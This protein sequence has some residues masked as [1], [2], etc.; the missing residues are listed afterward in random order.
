MALL[1][2]AGEL[3]KRDQPAQAGGITVCLK[4]RLARRLLLHSSVSLLISFVVLAPRPTHSQ[5]GRQ[6][7]ANTNTTPQNSNSNT[8][9][10]QTSKS[11]PPTNSTRPNVN[12]E[13]ET[14]DVVRVNSTLVPVPATVVD[15]RGIAV[16]NLKLEDFELRIDGQLSVIS[17]LARAETPVRMAMLFDNSGSLSEFREFEKRAAIRFFH[18]V[19]RPVDQAAVFSVSTDVTLAEPLTNDARRLESTIASFG[20]PEGATSLFDAIIQAGAYLKPYAGRRIIVIVSDGEDTTSRADFDTTLQRALADDCQIYVV[21]TGLYENANVRALAAERRMEEFSSQ[22][23]G[24][25]YIPRTTQDLD[26]AFA[27]IAADLAQQYILSYYPAPDKRD[28]H[29]HLIALTVKSRPNAR[30]RARRVFLV[31]THDRV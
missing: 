24:A 14:D 3:G 1:E 21:Q 5:S 27:Q 30:V 15:V 13:G 11:T 22:T 16:T 6:K 23:G 20:K 28:G 17:D 10:R 8:R 29:Y 19:L 4:G 12:Q 9:P 25:V 31:K 2:Q 7:Q 26:N 18:N